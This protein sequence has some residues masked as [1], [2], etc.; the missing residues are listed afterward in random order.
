MGFW[1]LNEKVSCIYD[2]DAG[3]ETYLGK[4]YQP[5]TFQMNW[6]SQELM[7]RCHCVAAVYIY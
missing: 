1:V 2:C 3:R 4:R 6:M 5:L 7:K